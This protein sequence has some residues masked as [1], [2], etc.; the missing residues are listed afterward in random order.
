MYELRQVQS[1]AIS[2]NI[3]A[4]NTIDDLEFLIV[5]DE[6][7]LKNYIILIRINIPGF[8]IR[9][10]GGLSLKNFSRSQNGVSPTMNTTLS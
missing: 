3:H 5:D 8:V 7:N 10:C 6:A 9:I 4:S 2:S 1:N